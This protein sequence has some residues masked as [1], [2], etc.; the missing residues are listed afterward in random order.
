[1]L[2]NSQNERNQAKEYLGAD[3]GSEPA[4][5]LI[6]GGT[7][8][9]NAQEHVLPL[10]PHPRNAFG[11]K[12]AKLVGLS[13]VDYLRTYARRNLLR[14]GLGAR[15]EWPR[16]LAREGAMRI[17]DELAGGTATVRRVYLM[18]PQVW[19]AF[20]LPQGGELWTNWSMTNNGWEQTDASFMRFYCL[21]SV[22][23]LN[24]VTTLTQTREL[25]MKAVEARAQEQRL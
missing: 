20:C 2:T 9:R 3:P 17:M 11:A 4:R 21:P 14:R 22:H 19:D 5:A 15:Q 7:N 8:G 13:P 23:D 6:V 16:L 25:L 24:G 1:M 18:G 12:L 10:F